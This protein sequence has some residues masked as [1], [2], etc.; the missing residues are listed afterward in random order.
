[1]A[2]SNRL[3]LAHTWR[4]DEEF[5]E[6]GEAWADIC[7]DTHLVRNRKTKELEALPMTSAEQEKLKTELVADRTLVREDEVAPGQVISAQDAEIQ[8]LNA[9]LEELKARMGVPARLGDGGGVTP[10]VV[11]AESQ[12]EHDDGQEEDEQQT[13]RKVSNPARSAPVRRR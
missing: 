3:V 1:M 5:Y 2:S 12:E 13:T 4:F 10:P 9:E 11:S 7:P 6:A 8:R